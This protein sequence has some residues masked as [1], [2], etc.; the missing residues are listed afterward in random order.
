MAITESPWQAVK[1]TD[2]VVVKM[3]E[4]IARLGPLDEEDLLLVLPAMSHP[5][6]RVRSAALAAASRYDGP[7]DREALVIIRVFMR[8]G[9]VDVEQGIVDASRAM[10]QPLQRNIDTLTQETVAEALEPTP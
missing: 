9:V 8:M 6:A 1:T 4:T 3:V 10:A 5:D 2:E 7:L